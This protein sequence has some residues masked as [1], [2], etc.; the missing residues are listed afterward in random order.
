M[1]NFSPDKVS[2]LEVDSEHSGQRLDNFLIKHLKGV[3][4][5]RLY[6]L[7]RKGEIR[8]NKRRAQASSRIIRGDVV[9]SSPIRVSE[10]RPNSII[11]PSQRSKFNNL[12][13]YE[14]DVMLILDKPAGVAVHG[15][16]GISHGVIES[17]RSARPEQR[18]IELVHRL[19]LSLIHI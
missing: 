19:D 13:I 9:R 12:I 3:P 17:L 1:Q 15:G 8:V 6:R 4:K 16:S 7:I 10:T 11:N 5:S 18:Y 14:N 2:L